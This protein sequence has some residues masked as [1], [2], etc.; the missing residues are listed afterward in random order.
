M[1]SDTRKQVCKSA[2]PWPERVSSARRQRPRE[3]LSGIS[4]VH[5]KRIHGRPISEGIQAVSWVTRIPIYGSAGGFDEKTHDSRRGA[6]RADTTAANVMGR[7]GTCGS[8][9]PRLQR[10]SPTTPSAA[11]TDTTTMKMSRRMP[12]TRKVRWFIALRAS[13]IP[14][15]G[16]HIGGSVKSIR[17]RDVHSGVSARSR[18]ARLRGQQGQ[19]S[20][21]GVDTMAWVPGS[22]FTPPDA[23]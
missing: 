10:R 22:P 11:A 6:N 7:R 17:D 20:T 18:T 15:M 8:G 9:R 14:C 12:R 13:G 4:H 2:S 23:A 19:A 21:Q 1:C 5:D 3:G 16:L